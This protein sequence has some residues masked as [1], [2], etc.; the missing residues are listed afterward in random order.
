MGVGLGALG[1]QGHGLEGLDGVGAGSRLA[2][3][4]D[5]GSAVVNGVGHV[6]D[7]GTGGAGVV[8]HAVQHLGSRDDGLAEGVGAVDDGLLDAGQLGE[9]DLD[10][11][12]AAGDHDRVGRRQ[13]AVDVLDALGVLD[14]GD[15]ADLGVVHIQQVADLIHILCG[16]HEGSCDEIEA[17]LDA[18]DDVVPVALAHVGHGQVDAGD[19]D[20]L[21]VLDLAGVQ[22]GADDVGVGDFLDGQLDQAVVQHDAAA[23]LD[24]VGQVLIGDGDDVLGALHLAGGEGEGLAGLQRLGTVL[25]I[26]QADLGALGVQQGGDGLVQLLTDGLQSIETAL[27]LLVGAVG[28]VEAGD[29]HPVLNQP[30]QHAFLV[31]GGAQG[32]DDLGFA[33]MRYLLALP[34]AVC[35]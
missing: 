12:V 2:R 17:L 31:G 16:A 3:Q 26:L 7:L 23:G 8:D 34:Y 29:V 35:I 11:Q 20:A 27:V 19:V 15:D 22:D 6:R 13:D 5:G 9:V 24:V 30:P 18:E 1:D 32:A 14:L 33:H 10:T 4:H 25:K 28:K 21:L